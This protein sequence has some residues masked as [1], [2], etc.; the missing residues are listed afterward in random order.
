[1]AL[2]LSSGARTLARCV[3]PC[4]SAILSAA[5]PRNFA[6]TA[7]VSAVEAEPQ[8]TAL[9]DFHVDKGAKMVPFAGYAMP[10][11]YPDLSHPA[12]H[13]HTR[14]HVRFKLLLNC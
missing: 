11:S 10:V 13:L 7:A 12:S 14:Q 8:R 1:M 4:R 6:A 9:Y 3:L 2:S 5:A